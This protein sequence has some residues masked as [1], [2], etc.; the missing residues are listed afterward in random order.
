VRVLLIN[1][2]FPPIGG[3]ASSSS[4]SLARELVLRG[5]E[6]EVLTA[7]TSGQTSHEI[8]DGVRIHRVASWRHSIHHC[9]LR[10]AASFAAFGLPRLRAL[11]RTGRYDVIHCY[12]ALPCGPLGLYGHHA[13]GVPYVLSLRGSDVP[14]YDPTNR[15][16]AVM[17]RVCARLYRRALLS[18]ASV[19]ANSASLRDL[20]S[21]SCA[22][23][24]YEVIPNAALQLPAPPRQRIETTGPVRVLCVSRL[25][26]RKNIDVLL[27]AFVMLNDT[28]ATLDVVGTGQQTDYLRRLAMSLRLDSRVRFH[29]A[30]DHDDVLRYCEAADVFVLPALAESCS[31]AI[32]EAMTAG[33]AVV[34]TRVGGNLD[35]VSEGVNGLLVAPGDV[36][37]LATALRRL[38]VNDRERIALGSASKSRI[39]REFSPAAHARR[40]EAVYARAMA[41]A[42]PARNASG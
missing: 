40:Y 5:H 6:V 2:E 21:E 30:L 9:G 31:M 8:R 38:I 41:S 13:A 23:A 32:I 42:M 26:A 25:V 27:K 11:L 35:L 14:G 4:E 29:G 1:Y 33:L 18:A 17:H 36:A 34:T 3:G 37:E 19:V 10:G 16:L 15:S 20:A 39:E 24:R 28:P 12:F 22:D 7:R